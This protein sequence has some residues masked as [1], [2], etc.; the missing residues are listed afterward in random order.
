MAR[1]SQENPEE[2]RK[3]EILISLE[4]DTYCRMIHKRAGKLIEELLTK[5]VNDSIK[6]YGNVQTAAIIHEITHNS[7]WRAASAL[8]DDWF[9]LKERLKI[10]NMTTTFAGVRTRDPKIKWATVTAYMRTLR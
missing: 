3:I 4:N 1:R 2:P 8:S 10:L 7:N 6:P 9:E 5:H